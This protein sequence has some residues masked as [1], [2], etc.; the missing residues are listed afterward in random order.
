M[1][2]RG[3][4]GVRISGT[5]CGRCDSDDRHRGADGAAFR[6]TYP[7]SRALVST[8]RSLA[9]VM[10]RERTALKVIQQMLV[11]RRETSP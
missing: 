4:T 8:L 9:S 1:R 2:S 6:L 5:G 3:W 11:N 10:Q 7:F